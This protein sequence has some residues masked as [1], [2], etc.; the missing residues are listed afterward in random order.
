VKFIS[1][2]FSGL[3]GFITVICFA[4]NKHPIKATLGQQK[5]YLVFILLYPKKVKITKKS[6]K[7]RFN[8]LIKFNQ[9]LLFK[10]QKVKWIY[11]TCIP[12]GVNF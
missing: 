7:I 12:L 9:S 5:K 4:T 11:T 2:E 8:P 10:K 1:P 6:N 3:W